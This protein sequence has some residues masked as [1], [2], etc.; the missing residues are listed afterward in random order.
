MA[1]Q[2]SSPS[3]LAVA[4]RGHANAL[5]FQKTG[6]QIADFAIVIDDE[7]VRGLVHGM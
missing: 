2:P 5:F 1:V 3:F 6:E 4:D 7:Y